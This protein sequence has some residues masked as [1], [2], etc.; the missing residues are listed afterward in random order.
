MV[1]TTIQ[2]VFFLQMIAN[3]Y[4]EIFSNNLTQYIYRLSRGLPDT[5]LADGS[6]VMETQLW[7]VLLG[8]VLAISSCEGNSLSLTCS[9]KSSTLCGAEMQWKGRGKKDEKKNCKQKEAWE[10][11]EL[12]LIESETIK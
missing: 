12:E 2:L 8:S 7:L 4:L 3:Q 9:K 10:H 11:S 1:S 6:E 5:A